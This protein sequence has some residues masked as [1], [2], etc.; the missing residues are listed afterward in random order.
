MTQCRQKV[1]VMRAVVLAAFLSLAWPGYVLANTCGNAAFQLTQYAAQVNQIA[2]WEQAQG[3]PMRCGGNPMCIQ[4]GLQQ[5]QNWYIQQ[6]SIVNR[7]YMQLAQSCNTLPGHT[8]P[9]PIDLKK[10]EEIIIDDENKE[11][12]IKVPSTPEGFQSRR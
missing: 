12:V 3:I 7:T 11:V 5:L 1:P 2:Q 10:P 9:G 8:R 6:S 4:V